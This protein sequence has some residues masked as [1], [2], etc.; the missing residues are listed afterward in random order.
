MAPGQDRPLPLTLRRKRKELRL[1]AIN[2]IQDDASIERLRLFAEIYQAKMDSRPMLAMAA[3]YTA[4]TEAKL[5]LTE[6]MHAEDQIDSG[7]F[8]DLL[9]PKPP[10]D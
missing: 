5:S 2:N 9:H 6:R 4:M 1:T 8:D 7:K 10:A 3:R